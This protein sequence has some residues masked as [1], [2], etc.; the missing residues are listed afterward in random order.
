AI[1]RSNLVFLDIDVVPLFPRATFASPDPPIDISCFGLDRDCCRELGEQLVPL[2]FSTAKL[3]RAFLQMGQ[4]PFFEPIWTQI[5]LSLA[6]LSELWYHLSNLHPFCPVEQ[7]ARIRHD[8]LSIVQTQQLHLVQLNLLVH[9]QIVESFMNPPP[10]SSSSTAIPPGLLVQNYDTSRT[11]VQLSMKLVAQLARTA[12]E[13]CS[14]FRAKEVVD[15][16]AISPAWTSLS[17]ADTD[18]VKVELL[19]ELGVSFEM[20]STFEQ[21]L[22]LASWSSSR[23]AT[24]R[25]TLLH[26]LSLIYGPLPRNPFPPP[27]SA[28]PPS[29]S[30]SLVRSN[31]K[32]L[33]QKE[34]KEREEMWKKLDELDQSFVFDLSFL[35]DFAR[36]NGIPIGEPPPEDHRDKQAPSQLEPAPRP[37]PAISLPSNGR[38]VEA[39]RTLPSSVLDRSNPVAAPRPGSTNVTGTRVAKQTP[40]DALL[41]APRSPTFDILSGFA[42]QPA[43]P[44]PAPG[45][46]PP[47]FPFAEPLPFDPSSILV[48]PEDLAILD[49]LGPEDYKLLD[50]LDTSWMDDPAPKPS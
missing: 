19:N 47:P 22:A 5:D 46:P 15:T 40:S 21:C 33:T 14:L 24:Q 43:S 20:G 17:F 45:P 10:A 13:T 42:G 48:T 37:S 28:P 18:K 8:L 7:M 12:V 35:D 26:A 32:P 1:L 2:V 23:A 11:R 16:L 27:P 31:R 50:S 29:G 30:T 4:S 44:A 41:P 25:E 3:Y 49:E 6:Y 34:I 9:Q 38:T 36:E 39:V